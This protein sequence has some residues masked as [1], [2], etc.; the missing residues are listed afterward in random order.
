MKSRK[1]NRFGLSLVLGICLALVCPLIVPTNGSVYANGLIPAFPGAE[2][3][4]MY[5]TGGRGGDVY[6]VTNLNDSGPGSFRDAVSQGN[7]TIVFR[8]SGI[9]ELQSLLAITSS[10]LTIAGQTSPGD[11]IAIIGNGVQIR[12]A[13]NIIMRYMRFRL[14]DMNGLEQDTFYIGNSSNIIIDHCSFLWGVDEV[15]SAYPNENVSI[16]W[17]IVGEAL[18]NSVHSKGFHGFGGIWGSGT[19]YHHNLI[20]HNSDR[21]PRFMSYYEP[22][23]PNDRFIDFR[24]NVVYD[25]GTNTS[26]SGEGL[27]FNM[28]N[29]YYKWGNSTREDRKNFFFTGGANST[30]YVNGNY[31]DGAPDLTADNTLGI[32]N[33]GAGVVVSNT[34]L[35]RSG[36]FPAT[37]I[38]THSTEAA[39]DLVLNQA[40]ALLPKRD[41]SEARI[42]SEVR[43]R[44][45]RM[46]DSQR[47]VGGYGV[48]NGAA[49]PADSDHDGMPDDWEIT[50]GLNPSVPS[51]RNGD[52]DDDGYT[53]LEAYLNSITTN[54][55]T[56]PEASV[57]SPAPDSLHTAGGSMT[58]EAAA[59][60]SDGTIAKVEFYANDL[61][62]GEA[63][64]PPY[65]F[66]WTNIPEG[67]YSITARAVDNSGTST[68]TSARL[69]HINNTG[70]IVPWSTADI[71]P[72]GIQG[73]SDVTG[74]VYR[75]KGAGSI[76]G[77]SDTFHYMYQPLNGN[78]EMIARVD[79]I[80]HTNEQ[81]KAG[82]MIRKQLTPFSRMA[83]VG[84]DLNA[85][86]YNPVLFTRGENWANAQIAQNEMRVKLPYWIKLTRLGGTVVASISPDG[87]N[88]QKMSETDFVEGHVYIGLVSDPSQE[89][90]PH[91][92][93]NTSVFSNVTFKEIPPVPDT[94]AGLQAS[95]SASDV[96]LSWQPVQGADSYT[97]KR[98]LLKDGPYET[99]G[100]SV[101]A[102]YTDSAMDPGVNYFYVIHAANSHGESI[103]P[104]E[105]VNGSLLGTN[106]VTYLLHEDF[107]STPIG[108]QT[109][110][111]MKS[112]PETESNHLVVTSVP[113]DSTGNSSSQAVE[114]F[115]QSAGPTA[116]DALFRPQGGTIIA[117]V[118]FMQPNV[119]TPVRALKVMDPAGS[120][121]Y[122]ELLVYNGVG[123][124][125]KPC[126]S[127]RASDGKYYALPTNHTFATKT[128]YRL[129]A[130]VDVPGKTA[131]IYVNGQPAGTIPFYMGSGWTAPASLGAIG[132]MSSFTG[133]VSVYWD[134]MKVGVYGL[135]A[136]ASLTA[137]GGDQS[138]TLGW[139]AMPGAVSY[140][141]YRFDPV[142]DRY[143]RIAS[144]QTGTSYT[145]EGRSNGQSYTYVVAAVHPDTG[146][147]EYSVPVQAV[148]GS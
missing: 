105:A 43:N 7:R 37:T 46:I 12:N 52:P 49:V 123:C 22:P 89:A 31:M 69:V 66:Q 6:E 40:G 10:N 24:N 107:E 83:M 87:I 32:R 64:Q 113:T 118:D 80:T 4:G 116:G 77:G 16:Q 122:V 102:S 134:N 30:I 98:S 127:Y 138:V 56:N 121:A 115:D 72:V 124:T 55:S 27:D 26:H 21:N 19:S 78:A 120:K 14:G 135:S 114:L 73:H 29:N 148:P 141:V 125:A 53:N 51:D 139:A 65:T 48:L 129:K 59:S 70:S 131:S 96:Q 109:P 33:P 140:N 130:V 86:L 25:W 133:Q 104:S 144:A 61:R 74:S 81:A 45:G 94:P 95:R 106:P 54:G 47:E 143:T 99:V 88:W 23:Y 9:I 34:E 15:L 71:G 42:V 68:G 13:D 41:A 108:S 57:V 20:V 11:G 111:R 5:A 101:Y 58:I 63:L 3:F 97:I 82:I 136:P 137:A 84:L 38:T 92:K 85:Q 1:W 126:F 36:S 91:V 39:Y 128:W 90:T 100:S 79:S 103:F 75:V 146:E 93:Y 112:T 76:R 147:G 62:L 110:P 44:T 119:V 142:A 117:Q 17:S 60:D 2:G 18:G 50:H 35:S 132:A 8:V 28:V 67:T 145:D